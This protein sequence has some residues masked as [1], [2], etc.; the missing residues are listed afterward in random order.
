L[1]PP[2]RKVPLQRVDFVY[3]VESHQLQ[4]KLGIGFLILIG[5]VEA[6]AN[7]DAEQRAGNNARE[8]INP[9]ATIK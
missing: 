4:I 3:G 2:F 6:F 8:L 1:A 9:F 7:L 5:A